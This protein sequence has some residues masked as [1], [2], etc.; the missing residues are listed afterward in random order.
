VITAIVTVQGSVV[1]LLRMKMFVLT[2]MLNKEERRRGR[3]A[4]VGEKESHLE[5]QE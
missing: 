4:F 2:L 5:G 3:C 1:I